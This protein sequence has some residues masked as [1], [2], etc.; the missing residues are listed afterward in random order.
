MKFLKLWFQTHISENTGEIEFVKELFPESLH[1]T[2]VYDKCGL[3]SNKVSNR[4]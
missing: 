4:F 2:D 3:L 1:Y